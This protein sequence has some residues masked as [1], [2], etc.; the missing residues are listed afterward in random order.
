MDVCRRESPKELVLAGHS[1]RCHAVEQ[2]IDPRHA[3]PTA[4][5]ERVS[6]AIAEK[7]AAVKSL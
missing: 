4:E 7:I 2:E 5:A 1:V 3:D 6:R